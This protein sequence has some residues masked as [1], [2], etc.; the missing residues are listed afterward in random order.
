MAR[1][2]S[3]DFMNDLL[4][5]NLSEFLE[6]VKSDDTIDLELR[7][8]CIKVYY[9]G[10]KLLEVKERQPN[11]YEFRSGDDGYNHQNRDFS[12][13]CVNFFSLFFAAHCLKTVGRRAMCCKATKL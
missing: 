11:V 10:G 4:N 9:R 1:S 5:G 8:K 12:K 3:N 13:K 7:N 6:Y 2:I